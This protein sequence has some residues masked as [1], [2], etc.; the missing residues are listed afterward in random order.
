VTPL[1]A[2]VSLSAQPPAPHWE[3]RVLHLYRFQRYQVIHGP[4]QHQ[5]GHLLHV[6]DLDRRR[7]FRQE[8]QRG[9]CAARPG[10]RSWHGRDQ[11][12]PASRLLQKAHSKNST[13]CPAGPACRAQAARLAAHHPDDRA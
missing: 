13:A 3:V 6:L 8:F 10:S 4:G 5:T 1:K 12:T 2:E 9:R 11:R 7:Y